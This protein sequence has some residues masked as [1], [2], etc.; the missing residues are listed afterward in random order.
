MA[1]KTPNPISALQVFDWQAVREKL[2]NGDAP[3]YWRSLEELTSDPRVQEIIEREFLPDEPG[4]L[5]PLSRRRF[6]QLMAASLALAGFTGCT[7]KPHETILPYSRAPENIV[8]G[9]P[10]YFATA[11]ELAGSALGLLVETHEGRPTKIEG[12]PTH[13][14]SLGA[15]DAF[16][17][18]SLLSLYDPDRSQ[19]VTYGGDIRPWTSFVEEVRRALPVLRSRGGAGL[20]FLTETIISPTAGAQLRA[21]LQAF[22]EA[23]WHQYEPCGGDA[24]R[25]G[26]RLVFDRYVNTY[27]NV[28]RSD[29]ILSLDADFLASGTSAVRYAR[30]FASRR[31]PESADPAMTRLYVVEPTP[32]STGAKADHH[33]ALDN[34]QIETFA[35]QL[36]D[37]VLNGP[38][39]APES[40]HT[41]FLLAVARDLLSHRGSG[42]VLPGDHQPASVHALAHLINH[43]LGNF[44]STVVH[45][46]AI[47]SESVA[48]IE[49]MR[50]LAEDIG[51]GDVEWLIIVGGNPV[52]NAPTDLS[53]GEKLRS[54]PNSVHL[55]LYVDETSAACRWHIPAAHYLEAWS[56]TRTFD[57]TASVVQPV[58]APL[59]GG[60]S[61][62]E[63]LAVFTNQPN[64]PGYDAVRRYW[65]SQHSGPDFE[66]FWRQSLH[67]GIIEGT[68]F[69][70]LSIAPRADLQA[71]LLSNQASATDRTESTSEQTT[72]R[73][74]LIFRPDPTIFD[75]RFANNG[76]LQEL[77][78]PITR[79]TWDNAVLVSPAAAERL[80]LAHHIAGGGTRGEVLADIVEITS[81]D[82][83][84]LAPA[85][86]VP[87]QADRTVTLHLGHG[88][89]NA[90]RLGNGTGVNG[91]PLRVSGSP[92]STSEI[93]LRKTGN[94]VA[95]ACVQ[96]HH[97]ME[98]RDLVRSM[99]LDAY[100]EQD[101]TAPS[102]GK[103]S[104]EHP[105]LYPL[106]PY[107]GYAW[108]MVIDLNAC[109]GCNS[110]VVAC[111]A[112][113]N[114][115]IVGK[116]EVLRG[117]E[118]HWIRIDHYQHGSLDDP[119][120]Y[121]Q[122]VPC[123][124]CENAP[125]E[126]VCPVAA[127]VH[128]AEG[129]NDM[130]YNRCV[131][132]RYCSNNCPYKVRRF[133]FLEYTDWETP[134]LKLMLNPDVTVRS[135]GV[136]EKC[137]Y[138]VQ[139]INKGRIEA[140]RDNRRI[141]DGD[142]QPAC[143]QACPANAITF[144]NVNDPA[145][146]VSRLKAGSRNYA[147][148]EHLNTRPRTTYLAEVRN[149]NPEIPAR[150]VQ[151]DDEHG[152]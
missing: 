93:T 120:R 126:P 127:T 140:E 31:K 88:R 89:I 22:P 137:T 9:K 2:G 100:Q 52:Y 97:G 122:P 141:R 18:A 53:F 30:Q 139:R 63:F 59:Y 67:E 48:Q 25:E 21:L 80:G 134:S 44:G 43:S 35:T 26:S 95:M 6:V 96:L 110:C 3:Q 41:S 69:A 90:G 72:D 148:L 152:S 86:I 27:Y 87:G 105:S 33:L 78:K 149:P 84:L 99:T 75:G 132:T 65:Q 7:R 115:P 68:A 8:P 146:M 114:I 56:D 92:N 135:R 145:S 13:P 50:A 150:D 147:L 55:S 83:S 131:G 113:N 20:R 15:S 117:R 108:G 46:N 70:P 119:E 16:A 39:Q 82:M 76:W 123:M 101:T 109:V 28:E 138:C 29:I 57:G 19:A 130:V 106:F 54:V 128:S 107:E 81:G 121:F 47:E 36:A 1:P 73:F 94:Q 51:R 118:M 32:S 61:A 91:Y 111:Q 85:W 10:L 42:V 144:G 49:S 98:G 64:L 136:M 62:H 66:A 58:I 17:Q 79:L 77:P 60:K 151:G 133:N 104:G 143:A 112:E 125:C 4:R 23:R 24:L 124:Q 129:L 45:T 74:E 11:M 40:R 71:A 12:N 34:S 38:D 102:L 142:V 5:T 37:A 103:E 14:A 116:D